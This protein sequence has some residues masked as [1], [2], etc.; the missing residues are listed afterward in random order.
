M[1]KYILFLLFFFAA[2]E[3][4]AQADVVEQKKLFKGYDGGMML[5]V[6]YVAADVLPVD[7]RAEGVTKGIGGAMKFQL[8]DHYRIGFEGYVSTMNLMDNGSYMKSFWSGLVND[9]YWKIGKFIPYTGVS[10]GGG[11]LTD[12]FIFEGNNHD[13]QPEANVVINK[14]PFFSV[15]P[16][17][18]CDYCVSDAFHITLKIDCLFGFGSEDLYLPFGPRAYI[19]FIFSH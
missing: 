1:R 13:W 9:F 16:F 12:C 15:D 6:G 8:G 19:G 14:N 7:Y 18:G 4:I 5:H 2:F 17:V 11:T 10:I 3:I